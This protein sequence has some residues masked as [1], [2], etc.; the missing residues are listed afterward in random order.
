AFLKCPT[1]CWLRF[2]GEPP[3][4]NS[5]AEWVQTETES[6]RAAAAKQLMATVPADEFTAYRNSR[7]EAV[8]YLAETLRTAK[9]RVAVDIPARTFHPPPLNPLIRAPS[10]RLPPLNLASTPPRAS[11]PP[12]G[13]SRRNSFPSVS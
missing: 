2:T 10:R 1:K 5:Y 9:W 7:R 3:A 13:A 8:H 11:R 4:G 6:Y 12:A